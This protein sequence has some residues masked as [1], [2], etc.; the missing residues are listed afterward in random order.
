MIKVILDT[1]EA[2]EWLRE[3]HCP[4]LPLSISVAILYGNEDTPSSVM[5]WNSSNPQYDDEP[6]FSWDNY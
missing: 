3:T 2:I 4:G 6:D 1:N 5:G